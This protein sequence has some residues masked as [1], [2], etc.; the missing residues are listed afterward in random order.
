MNEMKTE[1]ELQ[2]RVQL[3]LIHESRSPYDD[4]FLRNLQSFKRFVNIVIY[5]KLVSSLFD[6][7]LVVVGIGFLLRD[8]RPHVFWLIIF[9]HPEFASQAICNLLENDC[10]IEHSTPPFRTNPFSVAEGKKLG[11]GIDLRHVNNF[12]VR[13]K[14]SLSMRTFAHYLKSSKSG[15][16]FLHGISG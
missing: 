16:G 8:I 12:L 11:L 6:Y 10:I 7:I 4:V 15:T 2:L 3:D 1:L 9:Q 5:L 14:F 13:F